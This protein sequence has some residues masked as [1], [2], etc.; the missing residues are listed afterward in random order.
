MK[1]FVMAIL[2][3]TGGCATGPRYERPPVEMPAEFKETWKAAAPKDDLLRGR[4]WELFNDPELDRLMDQVDVSNQNVAAA[5]AAYRAAEA[6][7]RSARS[8]YFPVVKVSPSVTAQKGPSTTNPSG[9][10]GVI[11]LFS[12]PLEASWVPDLWGRVRDSVRQSVANAQVS[13]A[14]LENVRLA[15]RTSLAGAYYELRAQDELIRLFD[16]TVEAY[17]ESLRL[18]QVLSRTGVGNDEAV[19]QAET[20]LKATEAQAT[21]LKIARAQFEHA[22][23]LLIG[24]P[25]SEFSLAPGALGATVPEIPVGLPSTLLERRPDV[26]SAERSM[27]A[28]NAAIGVATTAYFP[29]LTLSGAAGLNAVDASGISKAPKFFWSLG[30]VLSETI[31]DG[32][33]RSAAVDQATAA[34]DQT[35]ANYRQTVLTAFQQVEDALVN[36]RVLRTQMAQQDE[37]LTAS[38]RYLKLATTRYKLGIDPYLTVL[39]AQ[40]SL[41]SNQQAAVNLRAQRLASSVKLIGAVGG[42]WDVSRLPGDR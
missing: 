24:K 31:F 12:L 17:R 26:A 4:W 25:A 41:L 8:Q 30:A 29:D 27:A 6:V 39:S 3:L 35:V 14:D 38:Q 34:Y 23:A 42:G 36:L 15:Q 22:I 40:V 16:S 5:M 13:A 28:A 20:Q 1:K 11:T 32:G 33:A 21:G 37:A 9:S 2:L 10:S 19:A 18:N 7:I